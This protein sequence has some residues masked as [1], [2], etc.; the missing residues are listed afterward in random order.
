MGPPFYLD[1]NILIES[2]EGLHGEFLHSVRR[3][4]LAGHPFV[5]SELTLAEVLTKP[6]V[7]QSDTLVRI[8]EGLLAENGLIRTVPIDREVLRLSARLRAEAGGK[9]P[10]FV[11]LATAYLLE[12]GTMISNDKR[13]HVRAPMEKLS[14]LDARE[15]FARS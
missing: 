11:H 13:M 6:S 1:S 10:D 5:T 14:L 15:R 7:L 8:Y 9:L 2:V 3:L 12:C 4:A